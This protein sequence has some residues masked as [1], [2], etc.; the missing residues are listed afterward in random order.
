MCTTTSVTDAGQEKLCDQDH[1]SQNI[2]IR[3]EQAESYAQGFLPRSYS[4]F[5]YT[6]VL[7]LLS[8]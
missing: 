2:I 5:S 4:S 1:L 3:L 8:E 6:G 7:S